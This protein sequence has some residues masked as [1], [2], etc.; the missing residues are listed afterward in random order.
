MHSKIIA[1]DPFGSDPILVTGSANFS[2][3]STLTDNS[4]SLIIRGDTAIMDIYATEFVECFSIIGF[5][6]TWRARQRAARRRRQ[7]S[8][9]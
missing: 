2:N 4:N 7:R 9:A 1:V 8:S 5:V 3:N 6:L